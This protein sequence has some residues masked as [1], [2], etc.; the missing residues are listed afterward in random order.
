MLTQ[1]LEKGVCNKIFG[2]LKISERMIFVGIFCW[3]SNPSKI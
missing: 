1:A 3:R 2:Y